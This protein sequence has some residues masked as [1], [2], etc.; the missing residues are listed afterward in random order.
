MPDLPVDQDGNII[1]VKR[2]SPPVIASIEKKDLAEIEGSKKKPVP[3]V[4][5]PNEVEEDA[6]IP[7]IPASTRVVPLK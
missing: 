6:N 1:A 5:K 7:D 3:V 2:Y 4:G